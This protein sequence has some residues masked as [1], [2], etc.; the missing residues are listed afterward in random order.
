VFAIYQ[1][2]PGPK[3]VELCMFFR[4]LSARRL[5]GI[6]TR[7]AF[8]LSKFV[9]MLL[10]SYLYLLAG[11]D[12]KYFNTS[13]KALQLIIVIIVVYHISSQFNPC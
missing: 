8:T 6:V 5:G 2:L 12:N 10:T 4:C 3:A 11:L 1:I 13:F 7:I 9:L